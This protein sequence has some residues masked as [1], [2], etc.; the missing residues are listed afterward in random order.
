VSQ[1]VEVR[2]PLGP[3]IGGMLGPQVAK[4]FG[5]LLSNLAKKAETR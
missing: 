2:G 1:T 3:I 5:L 4:D